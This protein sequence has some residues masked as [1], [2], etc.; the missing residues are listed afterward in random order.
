MNEPSPSE[1]S[2]R[3]FVLGK[4]DDAE[5]ERI[6]RLFLTEPQFKDRL[7]AIEQSLIDDYL[8]E[9]LATDERESFLSVY[10]ASADQR[11]KLRI[12]RSIAEHAETSTAVSP[13]NVP[14]NLKRKRWSQLTTNP[15][16]IFGI[17]AILIVV[18]ILALWLQS[19]RNDPHGQHLATERELAS[20]NEPSQLRETLP[21]TATLSV[22]PI[23]LRNV[24]PQAQFTTRPDVRILEL[25]LLLATNERPAKYRAV[26]RK[27]VTS[28]E[29]G[30]PE[31]P[32]QDNNS[33][34]IR[35]RVPSSILSPG[36]YQI[37]LSS[38]AVDGTVTSVEEYSFTV[39]S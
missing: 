7:L 11:R 12:A 39:G 22:A 32:A 1:E 18:V 26:L 37:R 31:L 29:F 3:H 27:G 24:R 6:E 17:A 10:A 38:I 33:L 34:L 20:L 25:H 28:E 21:E 8:E 13:V 9:R 36:D 23:T 5:R 30:F 19:R 2:L 35:V 15:G 16:L 4:V 14:A